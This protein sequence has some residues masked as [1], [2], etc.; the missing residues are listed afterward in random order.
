MPKKR[1]HRKSRYGCDQCRKRRV[2]CDEKTPCCTNCSNRGE[3]CCYSRQP[4]H[5]LD[6][7]SSDEFTSTTPLDIASDTRTNVDIPLAYNNA[8]APSMDPVTGPV[9]ISD[10]VLMHQWCTRTCYGFTAA[11]AELFRDHV[12]REALRHDFLM[13]ALLAIT[14][15]HMATEIDDTVA[16]R[17]L[18]DAALQHQ[19]K[20]VS[21][22]RAT[23]SHISPSNCDSIFACS[24]LVMVC[25]IVS[26]LLSCRC[27]DQPRNTAEAILL[28]ADF[29]KGTASVVDQSRPW[30]EQGPL[31]TMVRGRCKHFFAA[32]TKRFPAKELHYLKDTAFAFDDAKRQDYDD[33]LQQLGRAFSGEQSTVKWVV[34]V[35]PE[36]IG[37]LRRGDPVAITIFMH[38]GV[39]LHGMDGTWWTQFSGCRIVD[40][41]STSLRGHGE[42]WNKLAVWCREQV[43]LSV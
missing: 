25:S 18:V 26:P 2:K 22:L 16:A 6:H 30:L 21:G 34:I 9:E 40:D 42:K 10:V 28:L 8:S 7:A 36:F 1:P 41:L 12:G 13:E 38:W 29:I 15:L 33:A 39:L 20:S 37:E 32:T 14:L 17:P 31:Q 35:G 43:G 5:Q 4:S 24:V 3:E 23:L 11:E 19:D 27:D